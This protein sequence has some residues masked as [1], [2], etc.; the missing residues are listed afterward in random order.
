[1]TFTYAFHSNTGLSGGIRFMISCH[2]SR[3]LAA[4]LASAMCF[5]LQSVFTQSDHLL[6]GLP[7]GL[8]PSI[9]LPS[10]VILGKCVTGMR[11]MCPK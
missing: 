1:M 8:F 2:L 7:R 3:S 6:S 10:R 11:S 9:I 4:W 5:C